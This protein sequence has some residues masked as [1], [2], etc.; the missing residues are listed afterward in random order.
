MSAREVP[1]R[2]SGSVT[3]P[4]SPFDTPPPVPEAPPSPSGRRTDPRTRRIRTHASH[5]WLDEDSAGGT[6]PV[7]DAPR[8][9]VP[10]LPEDSHTI[11]E[12]RGADPF[13][14]PYTDSILQPPPL[15]LPGDE[16][17]ASS[18]PPA[19]TVVRFVGES[20]MP[21][22]VELKSV[23]VQANFEPQRG[24][25]AQGRYQIGQVIGRGGMGV[26]RMVKDLDLGRTVAM[27]TLNPGDPDAKM[28]VASLIS[29]GQTTGQLEHPNIVPVYELGVLPDGTVFY[30]MRRVS[31]S[32][33]KE[34]LHRL[35]NGDRPTRQQYTERKLLSLLQQVCL[36]LHYAHSCGVVHRDVKP[37]NIAVGAY[38]EV[39]LLDW[40]I[41][42]MMGRDSDPLARPGLVVGTPHYM[43]PEQARGEIHRV[44]GRTD[45]FSL[46]VVLHEI[47]TLCT[48]VTERG[49]ERALE[50]VRK[51]TVAARPEKRADGSAVPDAL[52]DICVR[53]LAPNPENRMASA[54]ELAERIEQYLEG[55]AE[56]ER[57]ASLAMEEFA[58]GLQAYSNYMAL[59]R[60][61]E[62]LTSD[63]ER[64]RREVRRWDPVSLKRTL[65]EDEARAQLMSLESSRAFTT[66][67]NH[68][69]AVLGLEPEH[70]HARSALANLY[71][72]R[73]ED[74]ER[75]GELEDM[76]YFADLFLRFNDSIR[77]P[78]PSGGGHI[79][80]RTFP[81]GGEVAVYDFGVGV[82]DLRSQPG[83]SLGTAPVE[84]IE[85]PMGMY[86]LVARKEG[87][88][89]A[90]QAVFVRPGLH[91]KYLLNMPA[92]T[93]EEPLVGRDGELG[94]L[95]YNLER[96]IHGRELRRLLISGS[97]GM[98]KARLV[99]AF[100]E[101]IDSLE[102]VVQFFYAEC[103]EAHELVPYSPV[104]EAIRNRAGVKPEDP[105][106]AVRRQLRTLLRAAVESAGP[107]SASDASRIEALVETLLLVPGMAPPSP[108]MAPPSL[109]GE[110]A[111]ERRDQLDLAFVE[112]MRLLTR[113]NPALF[114]FQ[115]IE[116]LDDASQ[117]VL[118]LAPRELAGIPLFIMG[119]R[120][121]GATNTGW[122]ELIALEA[123]TETP[124]A[125]MI[126]NLLKGPLPPGLHERILAVTGGIPWLIVDAVKRMV[127]AGS[128][129]EIDGRHV[130]HEGLPPAVP[131]T[132]DQA[133]RRQLDEL[134]PALYAGLTVAAVAGDTFWLETLD[135]LDIVDA[136]RVCRELEE[137]EFIRAL[138]FSRYPGTRAFAFRSV[139]FREIVYDA[140]A[141]GARCAELHRRIA[142]WM[143]ERFRGDIREV[144]ELGRH[145]ERGGND[146]A[147]LAHYQRLGDIARACA[148]SGIAR[149]CYR[150]ALANVRTKADQEALEQRMES[151]RM[152]ASRP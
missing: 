8:T 137:R 131:L 87:Y 104:T 32:T 59:R 53:A 63:L 67:A 18:G 85:L 33:L 106:A 39:Q 50:A 149:E 20:K 2:P 113:V 92:W 111:F 28:L 74:A 144:A 58:I 56:R 3:S 42:Y 116:H 119:V 130:V 132:M 7:D 123:L 48:P 38:G 34:V 24:R 76:V 108:D 5:A 93:A 98:G 124:S 15:D 147:A 4:P 139:F 129:V 127:A 89:H 110:A 90:Q 61:R 57:R 77:G 52:A 114:Y 118:Q 97:D 68:L 151:V 88:R 83:R 55:S 103:H 143:T 1:A 126:R 64:R 140:L 99:A 10:P 40:G 21:R 17:S 95:E 86:L 26:V 30:T 138:P 25:A 109:Q 94:L 45:V 14:D 6:D 11:Q 133:R 105:P 75:R 146:Q 128:L 148:A 29:E 141:D 51:L 152:T 102:T 43:A 9:D 145:E 54:G 27:K 112:F 125:A 142:E 79:T 37:D 101:Y 36:A 23:G 62:T 71:W 44:D 35:R 134:P 19:G 80:V 136:A 117:R 150:L 100:S 72:T 135:A 70:A 96:T 12:G 13:F 31:G 22:P 81:E 60:Q 73:F 66:T 46:G 16:G 115:G 121:D 120:A 84:G 49:T 41:A 91:Q 82:P 47:L 78:L 122:D 69:H 107:V 65:A